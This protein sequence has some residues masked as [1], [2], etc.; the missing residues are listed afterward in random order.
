MKKLSKRQYFLFAVYVGLQSFLLQLADQLL[1][2]RLLPEGNVGFVFLAFQGWALYFLLGSRVKGAVQGFCGYVAG[3]LFGII[4]IAL[5]DVCSGAGIFALPIVALLVVPIMMYFEFAPWCISNVATFFVGAG[6]FYGIYNYV[7]NI[8]VFQSAFT[9]LL[10]CILGLGSGYFTIRFRRW[11]EG[12]T[13]AKTF[14][15]KE[16]EKSYE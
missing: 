11:Y 8:T 1:S 6:A 10:Y 4:M 13:A 7:G 2:R 15:Y 14:E 12:R 9:V 5:A 3:I 16:A